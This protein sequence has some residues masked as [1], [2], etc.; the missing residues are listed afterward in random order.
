[1]DKI[2]T[3][4]IIL[5]ADSS[6]TFFSSLQDALETTDY[7]FVYARN[8]EEAIRLHDL[9]KSEIDLAIIELELPASG[10]FEVI[11]RFTQRGPK[12][13]TIIATSSIFPQSFLEH[14]RS[15]GVDAV[16]RKP[17]TLHAWLHLFKHLGLCS[18]PG[19]L[20]RIAYG[21]CP[22]RS[23]PSQVLPSEPARLIPRARP[24]LSYFV[25]V[26]AAMWIVLALFFF[27]GMLEKRTIAAAAKPV[28]APTFCPAIVAAGATP[29]MTP[30]EAVPMPPVRAIAH[31][32]QRRKKRPVLPPA[33]TVALFRGFRPLRQ[34][35]LDYPAEA[36]KEHI[37]GKVEM[38]ITIAQD[39]SVQNPRV[40]SG[41]PLLYSGLVAEV[42]K[43]LYQPLR[44]NGE[45]VAMV[46]ELG[47]EFNLPS[48][49]SKVLLPGPK[50]SKEE[51]TTVVGLQ[52]PSAYS[53][54]VLS[55]L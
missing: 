1:M 55:G 29:A 54:P 46:T 37:S 5:I 17:I 14:V 16:V 23:V 32:S 7:A 13:R 42:S 41:D 50:F 44:I 36:R 6:E 34:T 21:V 4:G 26:L 45:P 35:S 28:P 25:P 9:L 22:D 49:A 52:N 39:G 47:I 24:A 12:P 27:R 30:V 33:P 38:Q 11:E 3:P 53:S 8:G 2:S 48:T 51:R 15:L 43:W 18:P 19:E 10:G 20:S 40:L 31:P